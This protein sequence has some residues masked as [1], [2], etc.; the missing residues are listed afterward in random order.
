MSRACEAAPPSLCEAP[1]PLLPAKPRRSSQRRPPREAAPQLPAPAAT[2]L[3]PARLCGGC[4]L[5][6]LLLPRVS[7]RQSK[8][9]RVAAYP[10][11]GPRNDPAALHRV[12]PYAISLLCCRRSMRC[13]HGMLPEG[14][15]AAPSTARAHAL[16]CPSRR[17]GL[18]WSARRRSKDASHLPLALR[19]LA[20]RTAC[21][22]NIEAGQV[23]V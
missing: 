2:P 8:P 12:A 21:L 23:E 7:R 5:A 4:S 3:F 14:L 17:R 22:R 9:R 11:A 13:S 20:A 16:G 1:P 18:H 6:L 15:R 19:A 10:P